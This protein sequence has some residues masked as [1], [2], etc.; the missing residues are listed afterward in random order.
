MPNLVDNNCPSIKSLNMTAD[1]T[2]YFTKGAIGV[3]AELEKLRNDLVKI[4]PLVE[5]AEERQLMEKNVKLW[6]TQLRDVAYDAKDILDQ[7]NTHVLFIQHKSEFYGPLKSKVRDF[8]SL[9]HNPL[10]FQL[11]LGHNLR[12]INRRIDG[13][14]K[15][16][17]KFNFKVVDNNNKNDKP[18]RNRPQ[19]H[20]YV[21]ASEV[22]DRDE[23]KERMVEILIHD[24]F[25]EKVTVV[26]IVGIGGLG[27]TTFAQLVYGDKNVESCFQLRIWACVSDDFN[28]AKLARNIIHT[29]SRKICDHTNMEVLQRDLRQLLG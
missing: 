20:S 21:P 4:Q 25:E 11:Q 10:L 27:N 9:H 15:E 26:S 12:S 29:A 7:A 13:I 17:D 14:I 23:D 3:D 22:T 18:W 2:S 6:L 24:H 8:F 28:V 16:M 1:G 5:D 19:T